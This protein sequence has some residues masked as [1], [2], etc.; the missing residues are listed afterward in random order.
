M[1]YEYFVCPL[2]AKPVTV[3]ESKGT[4]TEPKGLTIRG[5]LEKMG[6]GWV[7]VYNYLWQTDHFRDCFTA[8]HDEFLRTFYVGKIFK[9]YVKE[10]Q[11]NP[12]GLV[13]G[14]LVP[15]KLLI[16]DDDDC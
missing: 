2:N 7:T 15:E 16:V 12:K 10:M 3:A 11:T 9:K 4:E 8:D 5:A 1:S 13:V 6:P 14:D